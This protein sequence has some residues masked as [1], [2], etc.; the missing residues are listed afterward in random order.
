MGTIS[1]TVQHHMESFWHKPMSLDE[2]M[3]CGYGDV[4]DYFCERD[5]KY[6]I[7]EFK[8]PAVVKPQTVTTAAT[9]SSIA[10]GKLMQ[11]LQIIPGQ[12][13]M[14]QVTS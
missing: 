4:A 3:Q 13:Q 2:L 12:S 1:K 11:T 6:R 9:P 5:M 7:T 14:L 10:F 8:V